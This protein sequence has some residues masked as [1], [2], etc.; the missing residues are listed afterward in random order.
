[1]SSRVNGSMPLVNSGR[2]VK[3][4][5]WR[6]TPHLLWRTPKP[7]S[8]GG[9]SLVKIN[10]ERYDM[11]RLTLSAKTVTKNGN[12]YELGQFS[13]TFDGFCSGSSSGLSRRVSRGR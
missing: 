8:I 4:C 6:Y 12:I 2:S 3:R 9:V 10:V 11:R 1:M 13:Q 7:M 5:V